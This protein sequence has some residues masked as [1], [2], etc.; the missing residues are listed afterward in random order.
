MK[1]ITIIG[2]VDDQ[3]RLT[4]EVPDSVR[5]GPVRL[6]LETTETDQETDQAEEDLW[7]RGIARAWEADWNDPRDD[8]YTLEDGEPLNDSR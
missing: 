4:A 8:I 6:T 1:T 5:P 7:A 3:H 2:Q